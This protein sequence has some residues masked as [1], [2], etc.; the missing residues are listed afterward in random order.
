MSRRSNSRMERLADRLAGL[1]ALLAGIAAA[2]GLI[3]PGLYRDT[4][5]WAQQARGTDVATLFLAVPILAIGLWT[6]RR[7][8]VVGRLAAI[9]GVLYLIYN[10]AIFGFSVAMNPL[11]A[12]YIATLGLAV[13]SFAL[14]LFF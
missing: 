13:W 3:V 10:Y 4:P 11:L 6:A 8:S 5:F 2:A 7:G 12:I 1:A 14:A 9:A